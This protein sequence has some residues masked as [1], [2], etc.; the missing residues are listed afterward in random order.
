MPVP[1][2]VMSVRISCSRSFSARFL[3][4]EDLAAQRRD[5]LETTVAPLLG[6][7]ACGVATTM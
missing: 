3:D 2:A 5:R 1:S 6:R 7:A 4:V